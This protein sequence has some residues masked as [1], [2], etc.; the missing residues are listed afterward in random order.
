M[1]ILQNYISE[2][3]KKYNIILLELKELNEDISS[4]I[5][6]IL[7]KYLEL[8]LKKNEEIIKEQNKLINNFKKNNTIK[9]NFFFDEIQK[10][11]KLSLRNLKILFQ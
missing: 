8:T 2:I 7:N 4:F 6:D 3:E 9:E 10:K 5:I 11:M 1:E